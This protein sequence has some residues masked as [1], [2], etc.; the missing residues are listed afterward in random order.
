MED[1]YR[2]MRNDFRRAR[3]L[4]DVPVE[5]ARILAAGLELRFHPRSA[6][7]PL[8]LNLK[9]G[10]RAAPYWLFDRAHLWNLHE[11]WV[12]REY[13]HLARGDFDVVLDLGANVGAASIWL[14]EH[15]PEAQIVAVEP[16]PRTSPLLR[17]NTECFNRI[18]VVEAA[19]GIENGTAQLI[20]DAF[21]WGSRIADADILAPDVDGRA[22]ETWTVK[23]ITI[24]SLLRDAGVSPGAQVLAKI[25]I[26]GSEWPLLRTP[27][28]LGCLSEVYG[29]THRFGAPVD[30]TRF[31]ADAS[32]AAGF[33]ALPAPPT[34]FHWRRSS[35]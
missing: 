9:L 20:A 32:R 2:T 8:C 14:H 1:S 33:E 13:D 6:T 23:V 17:R 21:S 5:R 24:P 25:D 26:E 12:A 15:H 30:S 22:A 7:N 4:S 3:R 19:V 29:E 35:G 27:N 10:A 28:A 34:F 18:T 31:F 11:V 16:D